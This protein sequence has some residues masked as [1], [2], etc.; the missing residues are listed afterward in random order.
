M[1]S[2]ATAYTIKGFGKGL[3]AE[4]TEKVEDRRLSET[5]EKRTARQV[6][7]QRMRDNSAQERQRDS[8]KAAS[9]REKERYG[10]GGYAE[11]AAEHA[12]GIAEKA[13]ST[14]AKHDI[15]IEKMRQEAATARER[16]KIDE[17]NPRFDFTQTKAS[18]TFDA[19][20]NLVSTKAGTTV[21]DRVTNVTYKQV[22][23]AFIPQGW[24][25]PSQ[26][27]LTAGQK[28]AETWLL[29]PKFAKNEQ[30]NSLK[31]LQ[32]FGFLP[33][34][35]FSKFGG[36]SPTKKTITRGTDTTTAPANPLSPVQ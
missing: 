31:F 4:H 6:Q 22:G 20:G 7:L 26:Q 33:V 8:D 18:T 30:E 12:S 29:N 16:M 23:T 9:Q 35:Y 13:A 14:K 1:G 2:L 19:A 25:P 3:E 32:T 15:E 17:K 34:G 21:T 5:I 36:F 10:P 24:E 27:M 11:K 28:A